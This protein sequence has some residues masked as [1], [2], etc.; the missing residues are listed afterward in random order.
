[1]VWRILV[2]RATI[3][4]VAGGRDHH[5]CIIETKNLL[6]WHLHGFGGLLTISTLSSGPQ[7]IIATYGARIKV[8]HYVWN[9]V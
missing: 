7:E 2:Y 6:L 9:R 5:C 4:C 8:V 1:V 3:N